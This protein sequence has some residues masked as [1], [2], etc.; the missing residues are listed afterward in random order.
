MTTDH[1]TQQAP[2]CVLVTGASGF[3]G[4]SL[5]ARLEAAGHRVRRAGRHP[6][7]AG[8][9]DAVRVIDIAS[10]AQWLSAV[11]GVDT[12]VHL[13][14][15]THV[16]H[17]RTND[18]LREYRHVNVN[19][20]IALARQAAANGIRRLIFLSSVKVNGESTNDKPFS[21]ASEPAP[22]DA[23][24]ISK[25]EAER[26]L[27]KVSKETGLETVILRP[28]LVYGPGVKGNFLRLLNVVAR[29]WPLPLGRVDNRR[30]LIYVGNLVDAVVTCMDEPAAAG[31]T[32]LV[33]DGEDESTP[34]LIR[35]I[36]MALDKPCR[37]IPCPIALLDQ[38]AMLFGIRETMSRL[39]GS[40][41]VDSSRIRSELHWRPP[42]SQEEGLGL[43]AQWYYRQHNT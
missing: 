15:R 27:L 11:Q 31:R 35:R 3:V 20:T 2:R 24:G 12:I 7:A 34:S 37:L 18:P 4:R 8:D 16:L 6:P 22:E 13:A 23:Y 14:A 32:Y 19:G 43:T 5:C 36:A 28:P 41:Q 1:A 17:D 42:V 40:L 21:E 30:S 9:T 10:D 25:W 39:T 26:A 38:G 33:S 29:G